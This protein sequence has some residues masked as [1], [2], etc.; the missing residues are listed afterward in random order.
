MRWVTNKEQHAYMKIRRAE[1][2]EFAKQSRAENWAASK[3]MRLGMG[4]E[5]QKIWGCRLFDFYFPVK[6]IAVEIDG[7]E[8]DADYDAIR[9]A[10]NLARSGILVL[11]VK[12]FDDTALSEVV[13][14][15]K[16][17]PN[18]KKRKELL[19]LKGKSG[20]QRLAMAGVDSAHGDWQPPV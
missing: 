7:P 1:N 5:R 17:S 19:G 12:N 18:F 4:C 3:L 14:Q 2:L 20:K 13:G 15:I 16:A 8:H 11:R 9:D 10:Y 6:G